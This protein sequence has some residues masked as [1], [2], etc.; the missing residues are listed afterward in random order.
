MQEAGVPGSKGKFMIVARP[1]QAAQLAKDG[2]TVTAPFGVARALAAPPSPLTHGYNVYR[3]WSLTPAPCP[4]RDR[5]R[6]PRNAGQG[7]P[8]HPR[9]GALI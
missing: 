1:S 4:G 8:A 2:A 7:L 9:R 6:G 5:R 3:P